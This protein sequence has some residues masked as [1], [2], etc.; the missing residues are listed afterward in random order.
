[1]RICSGAGCLRAVPDDVR[2]CEECKPKPSGAHDDIREH[3]TGYTEELDDLRKA[4]RWQNVRALAASK[5]PVC[6]RCQE[7]LTEII[8]HIVPAPVATRQVRDSGRFPYDRYAGYYLMSNLQGL[9]RPCHAAKT[10]EDKQHLG[11]WPDVLAVHDAQP[12]KVWK[13]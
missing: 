6:A 7:A 13:S 2:F 12:K 11:E 3:T 9:C 1:M 8:D 4:T 10:R 5:F